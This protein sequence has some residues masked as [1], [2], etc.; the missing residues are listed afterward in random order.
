MPRSRIRQTCIEFERPTKESLEER[1]S[2][3]LGPNASHIERLVAN[4]S[5]RKALQEDLLKYRQKKILEAA[6]RRTSLKKC[7]RDF[8]E[9]NIPLAALLSEDGTSTFSRRGMEI[10]TERFYSNL[11]RSSTHVP[12]SIIPTD[13]APPQILPSEVRVAIKSMKPS[14][15]PGPDFISADFL[16]TGGHPLHVI[17]AAHMTSY[18]QRERILE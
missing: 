8:R 3:R 17:L 5:C 16:R 18:L 13:E 1:S 12:S 14:T 4:T 11:F 9:Y 15:A 7:R 6:Q 2:L 10:I